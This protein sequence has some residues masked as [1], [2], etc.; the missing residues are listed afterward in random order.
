M[1]YLNSFWTFG[2]P[3]GGIYW[4]WKLNKKTEEKKE[5]EIITE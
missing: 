4:L 2:I 5:T 3:L 1:G